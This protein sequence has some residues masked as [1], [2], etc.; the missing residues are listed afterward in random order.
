MLTLK[1]RMLAKVFHVLKLNAE[2]RRTALELECNSLN[3][4][5]YLLKS[6]VMVAFKL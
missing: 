1:Q 3:Y 5:S 4:H 2:T 6:K